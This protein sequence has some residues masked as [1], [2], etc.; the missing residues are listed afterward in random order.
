[1]NNSKSLVIALAVLGCAATTGL[2]QGTISFQNTASTLVT[3]NDF[4]GHLG[5]AN[6][7]SG[8][9]IEL[10][11]QPNNGGSAPAAV[12]GLY[13]LGN[14]EVAMPTAGD[15]AASPGRFGAFSVTTGTDVA[16]GGNV[17]LEAIMWNG[18]YT[19]LAAAQAG[20]VTGFG[21][22]TVWSQGTG[23][24]N[25]I[26]PVSTTPYFTGMTFLVPEPS[27]IALGI[28]GTAALLLFR[29]RK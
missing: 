10:L 28:F 21:M 25:D 18:G 15:M 12:T 16:P 24:G 27:T 5:V 26:L 20:E 8:I 7:T 17:W 22:S 14:W 2:S 23:N 4:E 29:R 19:T 6:S 1:M 13:D 11:Y 9:K 3:T